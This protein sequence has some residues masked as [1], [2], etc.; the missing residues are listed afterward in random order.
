M[1]KIVLQVSNCRDCIYCSWD[2]GLCDHMF[3][4]GK[5]VNRDGE[6]PDWCPL[7]DCK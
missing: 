7:E 3:I 4:E 5:E 2:D 6:I 1:K